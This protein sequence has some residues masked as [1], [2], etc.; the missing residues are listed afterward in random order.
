MSQVTQSLEVPVGGGP[1]SS[2]S[3]NKGEKLVHPRPRRWDCAGQWSHWYSNGHNANTR[4]LFFFAGA[5]NAW[6]SDG[7]QS[8]WLDCPFPHANTRNQRKVGTPAPV[9]QM[10]QRWSWRKLLPFHCGQVVISDEHEKTNPH[11]GRSCAEK[12][13]STNS[14]KSAKEGSG[15]VIMTAPTP[16]Q[17][18]IDVKADFGENPVGSTYAS[19]QA[20]KRRRIE[21]FFFLSS[22]R[23]RLRLWRSSK[24]FVFVQLF[25]HVRLFFSSCR[26]RSR[27]WRSSKRLAV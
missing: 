10:T 8:F 23:A 16:E 17:K 18:W 26:A 25:S 7:H 3:L 13:T 14:D 24:R 2:Q 20:A 6:S 9:I 12:E 11:I 19:M 4:N 5:V 22:C 27:L 21:L 1:V 15:K